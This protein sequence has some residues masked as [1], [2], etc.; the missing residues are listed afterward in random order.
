[1]ADGTPKTTAACRSVVVHGFTNSVLDPDAPMLGPLENGGTIIANTAPGCWGPM[2]TPSLRGGHEVTQPVA[3]AGAEPGDAV[4]IRIRDITVTSI[5]TASGHDSSPEGFCLGDPYVAAR[6]PT[7]DRVWPETHVE[8]IGQDAVKCD[9]CGNPMTP[10]RI[11][12]GYTVTFDETRA[13]GLTLP[14]PAAEKI[15]HAADH[16]AALPDESRQHSILV[17]APS[18][19]PGALV[20]MRPFLGQLG[21]CPSKAMPDS[22]NAGD[23]G[24]FLVGAPHAYAITAEELA[25]HKTDGH[26]D[27]DAVRPGAILVC[28]VKVPGA[29]IYMG[30]M[31]AGQG[32]GEIA[33][34]TMD[35]A[36]SVTLQVEL[37]KDYPIDGPVLFPLVEDLP[38]LARPFT[39]EEKAKGARLAAQWGVERLEEV[40]PV[41]VIG[42]AANLN[43][44]IANG[45]ERA[46]KLLGLSVP[47]IRNRATINGA[48]EI[49]RAPGVIQVTF[50][51]P[52]DRLDAVGLGGY[53]RE[54]YNL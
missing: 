15:A 32:D 27:I 21:T 49:G 4:A 40:A 46:A 31:H 5:A 51:A 20:R 39:T 1:M 43:D 19:M 9:G 45:L 35:V 42:T 3:V 13:V 41:S 28:P 16:Y 34:H 8:G 10:F 54:Q 6:C 18:D 12:H 26:M 11:V 17:Y 38:P 29:G 25:Q 37:V 2:I 36:G 52:L 7:C 33:G 53:A 24:A 44:A 14:Q 30:D 47:E 22:H 23:F 50:L 48:I